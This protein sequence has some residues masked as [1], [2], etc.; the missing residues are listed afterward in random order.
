MKFSTKLILLYLLFTLG[1]SIPLEFFLFNAGTQSTE[2]QIKKHLQERV[3]HI[4]DKIDRFLFERLADIQIL[5]SDP[6]IGAKDT[7]LIERIKRLSTYR[8]HYKVYISLSFFDANQVR[9]ADTAGLSIGQ[10]VQQNYRWVQD[11]FDKGIISAGADIHFVEDLKRMVI[12][13]A[14]PVKNETD[15]LVGAVVARIS[16]ERIYHILSELSQIDDDVQIGI[17]LVDRQGQLLY[18]N[19][20]RKAMLILKF[21][22]IETEKLT[23]PLSTTFNDGEEFHTMAYEQ[24]YLNFKGNQ[25]R[26]I[27]HYPVQEAFAAVT[28]LRNQAIIVGICL[29]LIALI[30]VIIFARKIIQPVITLKD[31]AVKLGQGDFDT[32]VS[33]S[34]KD[35]IGQLSNSFNQMAQLLNK[36]VSELK[37]AKQNAEAANRAKSEFLSSMSHELRTPLNGILGYA[38]ILRRDKTLNSQQQEAIHTMQKSGEHLLTLIN[39]ILDLSKIEAQKMELHRQ[40]FQFSEFL[41]GIVNIMRV[42]AEQQRIHFRQEFS[43][44]LPLAVNG[45]DTRLRQVLINLLGN[46]IK[47]TKK[48]GVTFKV[49]IYKEK[50][51]FQIEDTGHGIASEHL[52]VIFEP[53]RQVGSQNYMTEGTGLGLPLSQKFVAMMGGKLQAKSTINQG[54]TFWFELELPVV[55]SWQ[56]EKIAQQNILQLKGASRKI[57]VIDDNLAN[58]MVMISLLTPLGFEVIDAE[59]GQEG[60]EKAQSN[61]PDAIFMDLIMPIM[62]GFEAT[63]KIRQLPELKNTIIIAASASVSNSSQDEYLNIGDDFINKPIQTD[64][65]LAKLE[66]Y[67]KLE[68]VYEEEEAF[69]VAESSSQPMV[70]P[71]VETAKVLY[72]LAMIGD[73]DGITE[74]A[75]KLKQKDKKFVPFADELQQ[76]ADEFEVELLRELIKPYLN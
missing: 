8:N 25:W 28:H 57:L 7:T 38:Q 23:N 30:G 21:K 26:L 37:E 71:P 74:Q 18:S 54:S 68:W 62:D 53:F 9:I 11:V 72:E 4:M 35:E 6:I 43:Q 32:M 47:F 55:T 3:V 27:A 59:N 64:E 51:R 44:K 70:G 45:D 12:F 63:H 2:K 33:V 65:V 66:K 75:D 16:V 36:T 10:R 1:I 22:D 19:H 17:N 34:S 24:G 49:D 40:H 13:F 29:L 61:I 31:A 15:Q 41:K 76:L 50:I 14:A 39:D 52:K 42:R 60:V 5:A 48:G 73:I 58:R 56:S 67:L 69:E 20:N 46:A